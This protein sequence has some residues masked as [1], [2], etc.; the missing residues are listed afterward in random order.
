[1]SGGGSMIAVAHAGGG[2]KTRPALDGERVDVGRRR[3]PGWPAP[4]PPGGR[5]SGA[6][7]LLRTARA[8]PAWNDSALGAGVVHAP[9]RNPAT[10]PDELLRVLMKVTDD[11]AWPDLAAADRQ[12][13]RVPCTGWQAQPYRAVVFE[14]VESGCRGRAMTGLQLPNR[15]QRAAREPERA[16]GE[17]WQ[18]A[19]V[20]SRFEDGWQVKVA[21]LGGRRRVRARPVVLAG[22]G[23]GGRPPAP[24]LP[25]GHRPGEVAGG[26]DQ[27]RRRAADGLRRRRRRLVDA[28]LQQEPARARGARAARPLALPDP[29]PARRA[30]AGARRR[31]APAVGPRPTPWPGRPTRSAAGRS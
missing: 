22:G 23:L 12:T 7:V 5:P 21:R 29:W 28:L 6:P 24:A 20:L 11:E 31:R 13:R 10:V 15:L 1:M 26:G 4:T 25:P 9:L 17:C 3:H 18:P 27:H 16:G 14:P 8:A 30:P 2:R 19:R